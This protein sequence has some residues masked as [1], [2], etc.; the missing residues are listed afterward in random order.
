MSLFDSPQSPA[1]QRMLSILR[2]V[3]ALLFIEHGT[4]K[5][6]DF[7]PSSM[8][9]M[10]PVHV[11][12]KMGLAGVLETFGGALILFGLFTRPIAFL[13]AGEMAT[14]YFQAHFPK[15]IYPIAN[16]GDAPV[17]FC[18][19]F[20]YLMIAGSGEWSIDAMIAKSRQPSGRS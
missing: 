3:A 17:L 4:Q 15:S 9:G 1:A 5:L 19:L 20:L 2:I 14:A 8:A 16:M 11:M 13:L 10:F 12:T 7:P 18:F 6:F